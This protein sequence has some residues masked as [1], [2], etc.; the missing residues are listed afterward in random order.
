M[1]VFPTCNYRRHCTDPFIHLAMHC[2]SD[3]SGINPHKDVSVTRMDLALIRFSGRKFPWKEKVS[4]N[5]KSQQFLVDSWV[6][7][8]P[9]LRDLAEQESLFLAPD[10]WPEEVEKQF[11]RYPIPTPFELANLAF[12]GREL[13]TKLKSH[14]VVFLLAYASGVSTEYMAKLF[15][16][17]EASVIDYMRQGVRSL[18]ESKRF[19]LWCMHLDITKLR[20]LSLSKYNINKGILHK[21]H[22]R[23]KVI[24]NPFMY[25]EEFFSFITESP[26]VLTLCRSGVI[27]KKTLRVNPPFRI[28]HKL[29]QDSHDEKINK[30][31]ATLSP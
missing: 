14:H 28:G 23:R 4:V 6:A 24:D 9:M 30:D 19:V 10:R 29:L 11:S 16:L 27:R 17:N 22:F 5:S 2:P 20:T 25:P 15:M 1:S 3:Y 7:R 12:Y 13:K 18:L 26:N 31:G 8:T 21:L